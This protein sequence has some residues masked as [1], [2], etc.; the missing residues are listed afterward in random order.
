MQRFI[1]ERGGAEQPACF[2]RP[3][4]GELSTGS[5]LLAGYARMECWLSRLLLGKE[6]RMA[7]RQHTMLRERGE[8]YCR[9]V[10][11]I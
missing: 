7:G 8:V 10:K 4:T 3:D 11:E 2:V 6:D 1:A 9:L 5:C